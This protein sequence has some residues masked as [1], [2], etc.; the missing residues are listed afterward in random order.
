[1]GGE[2]EGLGVGEEVV[3]NSRKSCGGCFGAGED[4]EGGFGKERFDLEGFSVLRTLGKIVDLRSL[5]KLIYE[6]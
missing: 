1:L 5:V 3:D 4:E 2:L 6:A